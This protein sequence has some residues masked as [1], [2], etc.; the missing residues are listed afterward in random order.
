MSATTT[1]NG[2]A[3][4]GRDGMGADGKNRYGH[5]TTPTPIG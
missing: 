4:R 1:R 5:N 3:K 2:K